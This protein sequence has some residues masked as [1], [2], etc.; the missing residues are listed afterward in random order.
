LQMERA[1]DAKDLEV[2]LD[3]CSLAHDAIQRGRLV[4][5]EDEQSLLEECNAELLN[6][7]GNSAAVVE[8]VESLRARAGLR[9]ASSYHLLAVSRFALG[10]TR[11]ALDA[12][13]AGL[14]A[15]PTDGKLL[16][17]LMGTM[18]A[19]LYQPDVRRT[20]LSVLR[21]R[22]VP[23]NI[24]IQVTF[25]KAIVSF[26]EGSFGETWQAF[27]R[28]RQSLQRKASLR[29]RHRF[30]DAKGEVVTLRGPTHR[31]TEQKFE[32]QH[33][34]TGRWLP[35]DNV[36]TWRRLGEPRTVEYHLGFSLA[37]PRATV[38]KVPG[39]EV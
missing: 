30:C 35:I 6:L 25:V 27:S 16:G 31:G 8:L 7:V 23:A 11:E 1:T 5:R 14:E 13:H 22:E 12:I 2:R 28:I 9:Y 37:G 38:T 17:T 34:D 21:G 24:E 20:C 29:V 15:F 10:Q 39:S 36:G 33:P 26:Y 19:H 4:V 18:E 32:V 3:Y